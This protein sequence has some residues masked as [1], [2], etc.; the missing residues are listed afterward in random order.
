MLILSKSCRVFSLENNK[1]PGSEG[2][3]CKNHSLVLHLLIT[4]CNR[5]SRKYFKNLFLGYSKD[6]LIS[7]QLNFYIKTIFL[8][9]HIPLIPYASCSHK[10]IK[11][12]IQYAYLMYNVKL[13]MVLF[14][15]K[16]YFLKKF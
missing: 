9:S 5:L 6:I 8:L 10:R 16:Y 15:K 3:C 11:T 13:L 1:P 4:L 7:F 14:V 12:S 2:R